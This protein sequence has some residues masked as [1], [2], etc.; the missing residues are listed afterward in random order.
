MVDQI[1]L[2]QTSAQ[3]N[4]PFLVFPFILQKSTTNIYRLLRITV[5]SP[6][7]VLQVIPVILQSRS[8]VGR[9]EK[10]FTETVH[11]LRTADKCQVRCLSI[12][13]LVFFAAIITVAVRMLCRSI[14]G[15]TVFFI[16]SKIIEFQ[17]TTVDGVLNLLGNV[18][19]VRR[20][21]QQ[22]SAYDETP[23]SDDTLNVNLE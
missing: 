14:N 4:A 11:I 8:Q 15:Q 18:S 22:V 7:I 19:L 16:R 12:G 17:A 3:Q 21:V 2:I 1:V 9:H 10:A 6:H 5:V 23:V 20:T 13:V